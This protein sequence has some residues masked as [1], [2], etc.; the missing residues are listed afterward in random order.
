[1]KSDD[2]VAFGHDEQNEMQKTKNYKRRW[3]CEWCL[4]P[5]CGGCGMKRPRTKKRKAVELEAKRA[6]KKLQNDAAKVVA[7]L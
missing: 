7:T 1:M 6:A 3:I 2:P 5:P 4:Y